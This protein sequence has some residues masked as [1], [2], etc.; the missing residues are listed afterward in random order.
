M[1]SDL[2]G[3][4]KEAFSLAWESYSKNTIPIGAVIVDLQGNIV[5]RG[6]N[7]IYDEE[8]K[9]PL[10]GTYMAHAEMTA[11]ITLKEKEHPD[12][13]KYTLYTT[14]EPC[15]MCFGTMVMMGIRTLR[16]AARDG[17][18]GAAELNDKMDYIHNKQINIH[19][20]GSELEVFQICIQASYEYTRKHDRIEEILDSWRSYCSDG[21]DLAKNLY[22]DGY[23]KNAIATNK[24]IEEIYDYVIS[25]YKE[26]I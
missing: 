7:R 24:S 18:A 3:I 12:I 5:S 2:N 23:F 26:S 19:R 11:M 10:A 22:K 25:R 20:S 16:Y 1:W 15:P 6:R 8:S 14:M 21:V 17:F 9:N 4:W 13:K